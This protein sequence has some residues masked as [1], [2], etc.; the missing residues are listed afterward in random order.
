MKRNL[1]KEKHVATI[2]ISVHVVLCFH[3]G[4]LVVTLPKVNLFCNEDV[5]WVHQI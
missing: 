1:T 2:K 5:F 4:L 3:I